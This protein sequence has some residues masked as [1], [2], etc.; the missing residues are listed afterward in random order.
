M[1]G[2][3]REPGLVPVC[4]PASVSGLILALHLGLTVVSGLA[5]RMGI[6]NARLTAMVVLPVPPLPLATEIITSNLLGSNWQALYLGT[7]D[8]PAPDQLST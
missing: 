3:G 6:E 1:P 2:M 5:L 8:S 7:S 4:A